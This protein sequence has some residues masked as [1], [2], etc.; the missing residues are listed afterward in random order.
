MAEVIP[1]ESV[2]LIERAHVR[3]G[4]FRSRR[5][6]NGQPGTPGNFSLQLGDTPTYYSPRHRHNFDQVRFQLEGDFDFSSDGVMKEGSVAY[7]PEGTHYGPQKSDSHSATLVLQFGGASGSGYIAPE[8]YERASA[9]LAKSG[10]FAKGVYTRI[11][12]TQING[13]DGGEKKINKDA[14]EAVWEQVNGRPLVYP[15]ERYL[16]PVFM[17]PAHF[18]WVPVEGQPGVSWK[19]LGQFSERRTR[20]AFWRID[21][22]ASLNLSDHSIYFVARGAG[23]V[24]S[25]DGAQPRSFGP[26]A[27]IH[28]AAGEVARAYASEQSELLHIGLPRFS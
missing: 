18:D 11:I 13:E 23:K 8:Q 25:G 15:A 19:L 24:D 20:I 10:T 21:A 6:L 5:I 2:P 22:G 9:E 26:R 14:Y 1:L 3:E 16:H 17:D 7:F 27:T 12:H 28:L 4:T